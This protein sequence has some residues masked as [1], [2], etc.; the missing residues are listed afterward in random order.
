MKRIRKAEGEDQD[1]KNEE[2]RN[3]EKERM[4]E[5]EKAK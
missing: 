2:E 4:N 3:N 5:R 1:R